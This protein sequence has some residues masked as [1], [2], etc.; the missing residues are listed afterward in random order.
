V[1][2]IPE[3]FFEKVLYSLKLESWPKVIVPYLFSLA[4]LFNSSDYFPV[5]AAVLGLFYVI[6]LVLYIVLMNDYADA[7]IDRIKRAMFPENCSPKT[8]PD[9]IL[10]EY[11]V[12]G[13]GLFSIF[14]LLFLGVISY[15]FFYSTSLSG[16]LLS[17]AVFW[18]Y[19]LHPFRLNY[20]GGGELMEAIGI[21]V[22]IPF[23][24]YQFFGSNLA[25]SDFIWLIPSFFLSLSSAIASGLSDESSDKI[26]GKRTFVTI[27]GLKNALRLLICSYSI[28]VGIF[29]GVLLF[30]QT[31]ISSIASVIVMMSG[32]L[33]TYKLFGFSSQISTNAFAEI[34]TLKSFLHKGIWYTT[35]FVALSLLWL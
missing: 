2:Q 9:N 3:S 12:L 1:K 33:T 6:F 21:S 22:V 28:G 27:F 29:A 20:R 15:F 16:I 24:I 4:L 11:Q 32:I 10:T 14:L 19:S 26:G 13:G 34:S 23:T 7:E 18:M 17:I 25:K 30:Q 8:I 5:F 31:W 35:L